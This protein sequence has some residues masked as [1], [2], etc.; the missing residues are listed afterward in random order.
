MTLIGSFAL[1][2]DV[3]SKD[4]RFTVSAPVRLIETVKEVEYGLPSGLREKS[5][6]M[7]IHK[8]QSEGPG[9]LYSIT[10]SDYP[11]HIFK[12]IVEASG[13]P[14]A[15]SEALLNATSRSYEILFN[16]KLVLDRKIFLSGHRGQECMVESESNG[17]QVSAWMRNYMVGRRLY[18]LMTLSPTG[19]G[20]RGESFAFFESFRLSD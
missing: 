14:E 9:M 7:D 12:L 3:K 13:S 18:Q 16:G 8:F 10:Y 5:F 11:E 4:G 20:G 15:A 19:E 2:D 6:K 17:Q 1:A